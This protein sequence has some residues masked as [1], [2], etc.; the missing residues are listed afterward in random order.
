MDRAPQCH[1]CV[2]VSPVHGVV[3]GPFPATGPPLALRIG[4]CDISR[5]ESVLGGHGD[6]PT[7]TH[8]CTHPPPC[9]PNTHTFLTGPL[10]GGLERSGPEVLLQPGGHTRKPASTLHGVEEGPGR[11][12]PCHRP[13][14]WQPWTPA[15]D[16][17]GSR[18][19]VSSLQ[20]EN[21][22]LPVN[23]EIRVLGS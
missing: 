23:S 15:L 17:R 13:R 18:P 2:P 21:S 5:P 10:P 6:T 9:P 1:R 3:S 11:P 14:W 20:S 12:S 7:R 22:R 8:A 19:G 16:E 4:P